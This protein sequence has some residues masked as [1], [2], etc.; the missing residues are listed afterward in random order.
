M[1][2][3]PKKNLPKNLSK[4]TKQKIEDRILPRKKTGVRAGTAMKGRKG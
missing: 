2:N 4:D 1:A 3:D